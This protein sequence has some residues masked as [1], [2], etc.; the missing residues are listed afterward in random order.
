MAN[1]L[2]LGARVYFSNDGTV[3]DEEITNL[4]RDAAGSRVHRTRQLVGTSEEPLSLG[5]A[6]AG[7]YVL[8][9]NMDDTNFVHVRGESGEVALIRLE[10]G[11]IALFR[12]DDNAVGYVQA[13]TGNVE[14]EVTVLPA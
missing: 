9:R 5:D 12:I 2:T 7:G 13:N 4:L 3:V 6:G 11:D 14:L 10:A 8:L 1:E